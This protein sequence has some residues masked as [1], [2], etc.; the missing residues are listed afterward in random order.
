MT[1]GT[2]RGALLAASAL[3]LFAGPATAASAPSLQ[4]AHGATSHRIAPGASDRKLS[5]LWDQTNADSG[6]GTI[7]QDP[8]NSA[9]AAQAADDFTVSDNVVWRVKEVDVIG[10]TFNGSGPST[11]DVVFYKDKHHKP[12]AVKA[13]GTFAAHGNDSGSFVVD[14]GNGVKLKP[15]HYWL[16][17]V[18]KMDLGTQWNWQNQTEGTHEGDPAMWQ[19]PGGGLGNQDCTTWT[20]ESECGQ[21]T[22]GDHM[23]ALKGTVKVKIK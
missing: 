14:L 23:F 12:G 13:S 21:G 9:L 22:L 6:F 16:S 18:A 19:N 2:K 4:S 8:G 7:S 15:G 1:L 3:V 17:V 5:L 20:V 11:V 10:M